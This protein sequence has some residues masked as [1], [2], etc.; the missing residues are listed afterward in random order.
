MAEERERGESVAEFSIGRARSGH[1]SQDKEIDKYT[2]VDRDHA[3]V[4]FYNKTLMDT[5]LLIGVNVVPGTLMEYN[6]VH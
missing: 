3:L 4:H 2:S 1:Y 6:Y 5:C